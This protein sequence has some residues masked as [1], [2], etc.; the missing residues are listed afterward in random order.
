MRISPIWPGILCLLM[1]LPAVSLEAAD[2]FILRAATIHTGVRVIEDGAI[3]VRDG[4]VVEAGRWEDLAPA[5]A[6]SDLPLI[7]WPDAYVTPGWVAASSNLV[8]PHPSPESIHA[9]FRAADGYD[10]YGDHPVLLSCRPPRFTTPAWPSMPR[11]VAGGRS[12]VSTKL[13]ADRSEPKL[14]ALGKARKA[15]RT[16]KFG[17]KAPR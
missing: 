1:W 14:F 5:L 10:R 13:L 11:W 12:L 9:D 2:G 3:V 16:W 7:H 8:A 4:K 6:T 17:F 15:E